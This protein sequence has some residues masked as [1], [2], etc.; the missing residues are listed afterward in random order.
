MKKLTLAL[1]ICLMPCAAM[2]EDLNAIFKKVGEFVEAKNYPKA[3]EELKWAQK[4]IEK[5]NL[6]QMENLLP[7]NVAGFVGAKAKANSAMGFTNLERQYSKDSIK[8]DVSL[9][10]TGGAGLA[11]MA[12]IG[13]MAAMMGNVPG[14]ETMRINGRT[15]ML[16]SNEG[17]DSS[18]LT[19]FLDGG[20]I[21]K[22]EMSGSSDSAVLKGFAE[23][24]KIDDIDKYLKG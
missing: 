6:K 1:L 15:A 17:S 22:M 5:L 10:G 8:I 21:L 3:L 14:Q 18:S 19:V 4:E 2:A 7:E 23:A 24:L 20:T 12:G 13:Q 11:G 16:E 9:T